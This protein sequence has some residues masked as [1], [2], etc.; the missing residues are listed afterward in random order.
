MRKI[1]FLFVAAVLVCLP[2]ATKAALDQ[3]ALIVGSI[4][5]ADKDLAQGIIKAYDVESGDEIFSITAFERNVGVKV[6][7]GDIYEDSTPEIIAMPFKKTRNPHLRF[8]TAEGE[9]GLDQRIFAQ[10]LLKPKSFDL[11]VGDINDNGENEIV[12]VSSGKDKITFIVLKLQEMEGTFKILK[13]QTLDIAGYTGGA[14]VSIA[15]IDTADDAYEI[16]TSPINGEARIDL[17]KF[18][19]EEMVFTANASFGTDEEYTAGMRTTARGEKVYGYMD[20]SNGLIGDYEY[21]ATDAFTPGTYN[22]AEVG[23]IGELCKTAD[24]LAVSMRSEKEVVLYDKDKEE[25]DTINVLS[26]G[27]SLAYFEI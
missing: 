23:Q 17:W 11:A 8:F 24:F 20:V 1:I 6:A 18:T 12:L 13:R 15:N 27:S 26:K 4:K 19:D 21:N 10:N 9:M 14:F 25:A 3:D 7:V 2:L 5:D 22:I 16:I